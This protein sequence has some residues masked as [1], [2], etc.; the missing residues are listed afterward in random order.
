MLEKKIKIKLSLFFIVSIL[1]ISFFT[2]NWY[3]ISQFRKQLNHQVKSVANIYYDKLTNDSVDSKYLLET[4]LP[5]IHELDVPIIITTKQTNDSIIYE[6]INISFN[7]NINNTDYIKKM[8][9][10]VAS[11]DKINNPLPI[12][13]I[14]HKPQ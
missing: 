3:L 1:A 14:D 7:E 6:H 5:L 13:L 10:I 2:I 4:L 8:K 9:N 11:M 12:L